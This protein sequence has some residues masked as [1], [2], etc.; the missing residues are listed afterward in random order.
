[1]TAK[2]TKVTNNNAFRN[3]LNANHNNNSPQT[4]PVFADCDVP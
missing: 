2:D 4:G 3:P 1:M